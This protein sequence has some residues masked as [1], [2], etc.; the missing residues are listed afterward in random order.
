MFNIDSL[1]LIDIYDY[2]SDAIFI[3]DKEWRVLA[4]NSAAEEITG[5]KKSEVES[6]RLCTELFLCFDT[7]G[8]QLC[9]NDCPKQGVMQTKRG[10]DR[11]EIKVMTK[12][13]GSVI[14]PGICAALQYENNSAYA[15]IIIRNEINKQLL[16]EKLLSGERLDPLT[17]LYHRQY[18]EELYNIEA[19]RAHRH[20]GGVAL[21]MMDVERLREINNK[22]GSKVGDDVLKG[23]GKVIRKTIREVDVAGRYGEDEFIILLYGVDEIKAQPFVQRLRENFHKWK[24]SEKIPVDVNVNIHFMVADRDFDLQ[25]WNIKGI[26]DE[27]KGRPLE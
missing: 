11:L 27:H 10:S 21:L 16:E 9:E 25:L 13:G 14:L 26:M 1:R 7:E 2:A 15:A 18:F 4:I 6:T 17:Q 19:K 23:I 5:W 22:A 12:S 24:Q 20:G 3:I 8:N